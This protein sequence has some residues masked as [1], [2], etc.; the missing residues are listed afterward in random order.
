MIPVVL[1]GGSGTRLWP[2]S[3]ASFPKQL[4]DLVGESLLA[5]TLRR[6]TPLGPPWVVAAAEGQVL[7]RRVMDDLGLPRERA[8][9]EPAARNTAP[10]IALAAHILSLA[11]WGEE[12]MGVFPSDHLIADEAAFL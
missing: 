3:R 5:R 7:T 2:V 12:V 9:F 11:G 1:S 10:A 4:T 6:V 8:V